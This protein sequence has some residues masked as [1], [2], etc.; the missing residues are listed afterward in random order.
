LLPCYPHSKLGDIR[1]T[2]PPELGNVCLDDA[3]RRSSSL[4]LGKFFTR[5]P[6]SL[7]FFG[8]GW[9]EGG[10]PREKAPR[11]RSPATNEFLHPKKSTRVKGGASAGHV[12][13][14]T[15]FPPPLVPRNKKDVILRPLSR[16]APFRQRRRWDFS[17]DDASQIL[18]GVV[19]LHLLPPI[20]EKRTAGRHGHRRS[21]R[22]RSY[23]LRGVHQRWSQRLEDV[24]P[25]SA[26]WEAHL[27]WRLCFGSFASEKGPRRRIHR[28]AL[29]RESCSD[30]SQR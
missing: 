13:E 9:S 30:R 5:Q 2:N 27:R 8:H 16:Q 22:R 18:K 3:D 12:P 20:R 23:S 15:S 19:G 14:T 11:V 1:S 28:H 25:D 10:C 29:G 6:R 26:V 4:G 21:V 7:G 24:M 17:R